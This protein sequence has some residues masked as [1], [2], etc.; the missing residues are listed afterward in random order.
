M[1]IRLWQ[2]PAVIFRSGKGEGF[3]SLEFSVQVDQCASFRDYF[4]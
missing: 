1:S 3:R 2:K 4:G